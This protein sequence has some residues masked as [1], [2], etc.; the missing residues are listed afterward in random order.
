MITKKR[1]ERP[2]IK[3]LESNMPNK[4]GMRTEYEPVMHIEGA[5]VK[6]RSFSYQ[7]AQPALQI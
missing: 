6:H 2:V 7:L 5:A 1:Y 3:K 4:F